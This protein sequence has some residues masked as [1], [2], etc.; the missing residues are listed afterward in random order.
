[1]KVPGAEIARKWRV[2]WIEDDR[3]VLGFCVRCLTAAGF[4]VRGVLTGEEGLLLVETSSWDVIVV[5]LFLPAIP[6]VEVIRRI[7]DEL[8]RE[9]AI[10]V[11]T[12]HTTNDL[13]EASHYGLAD[14]LRKPFT[15]AVLVKSI[16]TACGRSFAA[17]PTTNQPTNRCETRTGFRPWCWPLRASPTRRRGRRLSINALPS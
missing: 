2:L 4:E 11:A 9:T 3:S 12:G 6:G 8:R 15:E 1:M 10:V 17:G 16:R 7:R 14:V 5:D 13:A